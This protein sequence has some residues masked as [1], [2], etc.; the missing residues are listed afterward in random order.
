VADRRKETVDSGAKSLL[1]HTNISKVGM[2]EVPVL[3]DGGS[4]VGR[5]EYSHEFLSSALGQKSHNELRYS[6]TKC[7]TCS[8]VQVPALSSSAQPHHSAFSYF[9]ARKLFTPAFF[10]ERDSVQPVEFLSI[11]NL[12]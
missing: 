10:G 11:F 4:I 9:L 3:W 12:S 7:S 1:N 5:R 6:Q 8:Y 2:L